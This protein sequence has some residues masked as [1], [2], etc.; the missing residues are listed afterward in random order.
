MKV[1]WSWLAA[2]AMLGAAPAQADN[3]DAGRERERI[4]S[5]RQAA[6]ARFAAEQQACG[7]R[8]AVNDCI[9][10]AR[11]LRRDQIADLRRQELSLDEADRKRRASE[12]LRQI[13]ENARQEAVSDERRAQAQ[14]DQREREA[15]AAEKSSKQQARLDSAAGAGPRERTPQ[16]AL[17]PQPTASEAASNRRAQEAHIAESQERKKR[18]ES[19][20][21]ERAKP[22]AS[23]LPVPP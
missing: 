23:S 9:D 1:L 21:A 11:K 10:A 7:A 19:R 16:G 14:A 13:E 12:R 20:R 22:A 18:L 17:G 6:D 2:F 5:E 8:F 4:K 15:R 3:A